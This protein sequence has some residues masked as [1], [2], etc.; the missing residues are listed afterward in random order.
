MTV[1]TIRPIAR[2]RLSQEFLSVMISRRCHSALYGCLVHD[3]LPEVSHGSLARVQV[4]ARHSR[5]GASKALRARGS[6]PSHSILLDLNSSQMVQGCMTVGTIRPIARSRL[7][8]EF[9]SVMISRRCHSALYGCLVHDFLP[10]GS[11]GS[12]AR[13]QVPARHSRCGASKALRARGSPPSHSILLDLN[14]SQMVQGIQRGLGTGPV[15]CRRGHC[16]HWPSCVSKAV[17]YSLKPSVRN[18]GTQSGA[19]IWTT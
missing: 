3:F 9:L 19:S 1:G 12:L 14:S 10:E 2:S 17:M 7:S 15:A 13:V 5:C 8:Q 18:S 4:P 11:H 6:P 16:T